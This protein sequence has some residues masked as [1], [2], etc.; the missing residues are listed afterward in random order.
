MGIHKLLP[1]AI[2][3]NEVNGAYY[4]FDSHKKVMGWYCTESNVMHIHKDYEN[5]QAL[6]ERLLGKVEIKVV[7]NDLA[8]ALYNNAHTNT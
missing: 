7:E 8:K 3:G 4:I 1:N 6:Y 2:F 5:A